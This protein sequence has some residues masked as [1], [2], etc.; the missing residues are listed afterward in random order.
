MQATMRKD[1]GFDGDLEDS[2][3]LLINRVYIGVA[4]DQDLCNFCSAGLSGHMQGRHSIQ[5][6]RI[7]A[8][9]KLQQTARYGSLTKIGCIV[10][11]T[12]MRISP[13]CGSGVYICAAF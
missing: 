1:P 9:I 3:S 12:K 13:F 10:Q 4:P 11:R 2:P 5:V 7:N 8:S 6:L